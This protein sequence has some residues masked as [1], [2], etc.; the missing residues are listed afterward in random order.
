M[1]TEIGFA[2]ANIS[3]Q[4]PANKYGSWALVTGASDGMGAAL[5][6]RLA[7]QG[8]NLVLVA[9]RRQ[10][11]EE[12]ASTLADRFGIR[13]IPLGLDMAK[14]EDIAELE[15]RTADLDIGVVVLAA[16]YG[17]SGPF[18]ETGLQANLDMLDVNCRAVLRLAHVFGRRL[19][20]R[21]RGTIVLFGSLVGWQGVPF[22]AAYAASKAFVQSLA[23][24]LRIE[25]APRGVDILSVAPGPV[26]SGFAAR[27]DMAMSMA[28]P[29]DAAADDIMRALGRSG[30]VVPGWLGKLLTYSLSPLPRS[31]RVRMMGKIMQGM[32]EPHGT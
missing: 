9:R 30:D 13:V 10:V 19:A 15:S 27:A 2:G 22:S 21:R 11:L 1:K 29:A 14:P 12:K 26:A 24:G 5:A 16:G 23:E 25:L 8:I 7:A 18:I 20:E 4:S 6:D 3:P 32:T 17:L 31:L 28:T